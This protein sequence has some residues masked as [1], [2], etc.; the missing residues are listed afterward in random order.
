[1]NRKTGIFLTASW[2]TIAFSCVDLRAQDTSRVPD[3]NPQAASSVDA[4][5]HADIEEGA[6]Q[7]QPPQQANK[8]PASYSKWGFQSAN[9]PSATQ[10]RPAQATTPGLAA[11][12]NAKNLSSFASPSVQAAP[13]EP[14]SA[15]W[16]GRATNS[17]IAPANHTSSTK[18]DRWSNLFGV[19]SPNSQ[20]DRST[21]RQLFAPQALPSSAQPASPAFSTPFREKQFGGL[22]ASSFPTPFPK[23]YSSSQDQAKTKQHKPLPLKSG[24][25]QHAGAVTG[26]SG[27]Q[28]KKIG[29][30]LTTRL[31]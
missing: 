16:P 5:V 3:T 2:V 31:K 29:S 10:F 1:M 26:S 28:K 21:G 30:Q 20:R 25:K 9:Q 11:S 12:A 24:E 27:D 18:S 4:A 7:R 14:N 22:G 15:D 8:R 6:K 19:S 13:R 23:T 17:T